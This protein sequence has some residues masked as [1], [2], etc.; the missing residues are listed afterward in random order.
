MFQPERQWEKMIS[1]RK[2]SDDESHTL[3]EYAADRMICFLR[4]SKIAIGDTKLREVLQN[5]ESIN[6]FILSLDHADYKRLLIGV[7]AMVRNKSGDQEWTLDGEG[8]KMGNSNIFPDQIDKEDLLHKSLEVAKQMQREGRSTEDIAILLAVALTA[9]H[10][11]ANG[12]GR[13]ARVLLTL[14]NAGYDPNLLKDVIKSRNFGNAVNAASFQAKA[15]QVLTTG[16]SDYEFTEWVN[17]GVNRSRMAE[18][19]ID[20]IHNNENPA[21]I[22]GRD[23]SRSALNVFKEKLGWNTDQ[24][25]RERVFLQD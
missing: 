17:I 23:S 16:L 14:L 9:I 20:M 11:F 12:N 4:T 21:Y 7:N 6:D 19:V 5:K 3:R 24:S 2:E 10:P 22:L 18:L 13:T 15:V 25:L 1:S 8:V